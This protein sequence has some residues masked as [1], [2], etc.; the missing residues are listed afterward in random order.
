MT[1]RTRNSEWAVIPTGCDFLLF[2]LPFVLTIPRPFV[3]LKLSKR[4]GRTYVF[5]HSLTKCPRR[6]M[7]HVSPS[8]FQVTKHLGEC[9]PSTG[10]TAQ[11]VT[12][13]GALRNN[14]SGRDIASK[15]EMTGKKRHDLFPLCRRPARSSLFMERER[16]KLHA[17]AGPTPNSDVYLSRISPHLCCSSE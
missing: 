5:C 7:H 11:I 2:G 9:K 16:S 13:H 17:F 6:I 4:C 12:R 15:A 10:R 14:A 1:L 8:S 3:I